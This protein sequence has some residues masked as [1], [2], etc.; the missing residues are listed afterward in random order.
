MKEYD[1]LLIIKKLNPDKAHGWDN[2]SIRMI[3]LCV[4]DIVKPLKY[5]SESS[6]TTGIFAEDWKKWNIVP[7]HKKQSK[8]C[9]KNYRPISVLLIFSKIFEILIFNALFNFFVHNE[10]FT[11]CQ[12]GFIPGDSYVSQLL[13]ISQEIHKSF[14]CNPSD[15]VRGVFLD[16]CKALDKVWHEGLICKLKTFGNCN[17]TRT[18]SQ[19]VCK[20]TLN[21]LA[22][23]AKWLGV[24]LRTKWLWV[25][26]PLQSFMTFL[27]NLPME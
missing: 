18:H 9:L 10:L 5:L 17:G 27:W 7:V 23:L 14:D 26:V 12:S 22:S 3:Q 8:T 21:H 11:E 15:D 16:I 6:L 25:R 19:L 4:E 20:R 24:R 1:E 13:S 2:V